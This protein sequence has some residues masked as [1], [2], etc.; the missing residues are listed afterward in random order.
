MESTGRWSGPTNSAEAVSEIRSRVERLQNLR[1]RFV[2]RDIN[3]IR[4]DIEKLSQVIPQRERTLSR[5]R[6][7][8]ELERKMICALLPTESLDV[9]LL[10]SSA[11]KDLP[12]NLNAELTK[13]EQRFQERDE[14]L[15]KIDVDLQAVLAKGKT[16]DTRQ[17]Y[18]TLRDQAILP[19]QSV[20]AELQKMFSPCRFCRPERGLKVFCFR[21][22]TSRLR[23][24]SEIAKVNRLDG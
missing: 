6:E 1:Q 9:A 16:G 4:K 15:R 23:K 17:Q 18:E 11:L 19:S 3:E 20:L 2:G 7:I 10:D 21:R 24:R 5:L 22:L 14:R 13:L 8:Y 12:A